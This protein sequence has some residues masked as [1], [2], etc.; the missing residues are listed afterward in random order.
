M[1]L[2]CNSDHI[3][4]LLRILQGSQG[5]TR[6]PS[7]FP[8]SCCLHLPLPSF[9]FPSSLRDFACP[10]AWIILFPQLHAARS[11]SHFSDLSWNIT[12]ASCIISPQ[13][14]LA[15]YLAVFIFIALTTISM[16]YIHL[17]PSSLY[18]KATSCS[19]LHPR[20]LEHSVPD[21]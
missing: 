2:K 17:L 8:S 4:L 14:I 7:H 1:F 9:V 3:T 21:I 18:L 5:P 19:L 13:H 15:P 12:L 16:P 10:F 20:H 6:I 11:P